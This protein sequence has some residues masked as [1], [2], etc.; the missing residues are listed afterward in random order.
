MISPNEDPQKFILAGADRACAAP[1]SKEWLMQTLRD[2]DG[3]K[4]IETALIVDDLEQDRYLIRE[5]LMALGEFDVIEA[6]TGQEAFRRLRSALPD[7]I[8]LDLALPDMSGFEILDHLKRDDHTKNVPVIINTSPILGD[9]DR[10]RLAGKA[11]DILTKGSDSREQ[12]IAQVRGSLKK[13][14]LHI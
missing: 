5:S 11:V 1:L 10:N 8:F 7:V 12:A 6:E 2:F 4:S 3:R 14:G 9:D 13:A